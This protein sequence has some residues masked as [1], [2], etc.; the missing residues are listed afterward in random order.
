MTDCD[1]T[2]CPGATGATGETDGETG[3][4]ATFVETGL[5]DQG[6]VTIGGR[7][8]LALDDAG[9]SDVGDDAACPGSEG[10]GGED[11]GW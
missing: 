10:R 9:A 11:G 6:G 1:A 5:V 8:G 3:M 4:W 7:G 2:C